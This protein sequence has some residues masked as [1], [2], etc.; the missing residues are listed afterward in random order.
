M[1]NL[2]QLQDKLQ[3]TFKDTSLL[4]LAL[5][6]CSYIHRKMDE[7]SHN[8][9]LEFLGDAVLQLYSSA[10]LYARFPQANESA[11]SQARAAL[12]CEEALAGY[13]RAMHVGDCLLLGNGEMHTGGN[14][15]DSILA[16]TMEAIIGAIYLDGGEVPART[17]ISRLLAP[18]CENAIIPERRLDAKTTLQMAC[19]DLGQVTYQIVGQSGP[20]HA[21]RFFAHALL[22]DRVI[23]KGEGSSKKHA[24]KNA[25]QNALLAFQKREAGK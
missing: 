11:L 15:R 9:R 12:V 2:L 22:Q 13:A 18:E 6:H 4:Q 17:L 10:F 3:Y 21:R 16:D 1:Q 23:G 24:E 5:T 7:T 19:A 8:Q 20:D 14:D 25:A